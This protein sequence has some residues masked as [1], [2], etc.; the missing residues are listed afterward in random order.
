ME[1]Q[2]LFSVFDIALIVGMGAFIATW[3]VVYH[4]PEVCDKLALAAQAFSKLLL[5]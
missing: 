2:S 5:A 1:K 3:L 4:H